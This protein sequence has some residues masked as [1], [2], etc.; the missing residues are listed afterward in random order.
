MP[1]TEEQ[2]KKFAVLYKQGKMSKAEFD[3]LMGEGVKR[4]PKIPN[5]GKGEK[6]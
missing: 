4:D 6:K 3:R 2:R 5:Y 1:Y